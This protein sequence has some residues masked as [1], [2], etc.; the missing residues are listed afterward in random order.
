MA[1]NYLGLPIKEFYRLS[2]REFDLALKI[3]LD[4]LNKS[5]KFDRDLMRMQTMFLFNVHVKA[6]SR[7][8]NPRLF[9]PFPDEKAL[10]EKE[11]EDQINSVDWNAIDNK[12]ARKKLK[13]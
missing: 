9:M 7:Q 3:R 13:N 4:D 8:W 2:P 5:N 1:L 11:M 12:F 6:Q 10:I